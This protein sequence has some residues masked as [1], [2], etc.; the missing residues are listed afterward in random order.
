VVVTVEI[1][2]TLTAEEAFGR[3]TV[4]GNASD[5]DAANAAGTAAVGTPKALKQIFSSDQ[6]SQS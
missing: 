3:D 1:Q 4:A 6:T 2:D 5:A